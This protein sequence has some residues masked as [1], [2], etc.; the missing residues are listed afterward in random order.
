LNQHEVR[1]LES[2]D[3]E[4]VITLLDHVFNGWHKNTLNYSPLEYWKW[5]FQDNPAKRGHPASVA[6]KDG[7]IVGCL[8]DLHMVCKLGNK[9]IFVG[10]GCDLAVHP[11]H[12]RRGLYN[13][14]LD[15]LDDSRLGNNISMCI[16]VTGNPILWKSSDRKGIPRL[17]SPALYLVRV[18]DIDLHL[19]YRPMDNP[20]VIKVGVNLLKMIQRN[21]KKSNEQN[22]DIKLK[23]VTSF[24]DEAKEYYNKIKSSYNFISVKS[25]EYL[26]WRFCDKRGGNYLV[27][28]AYIENILEGYIV[29]KVNRVDPDYLEGS[30]VELQYH[31][32]RF[33]V[34]RTLLNDSMS[35][36]DSE[37]VNIIY[38]WVLRNQSIIRIYENVGFI[39][40]RR[41]QQVRVRTLIPS[42]NLDP[43]MS[44][45]ID[46]VEY[47]YA[48]SD[49]R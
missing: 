31:P 9:E 8:H 38:T 12:R 10:Q 27:T 44:S 16:S 42:L 20:W 13:K 22:A 41:D 3:E 24:D 48:Y 14:M 33:D 28:A 15:K 18:R 29:S 23:R 17:Q 11:E 32:G 35:Y 34:A 1:F 46:T 6:L 30:I 45:N 47:N 19:K 49:W 37:N 40:S 25:P 43:V 36:F 26:N 7:K 4:E 39:N 2:G 21:T 5:K